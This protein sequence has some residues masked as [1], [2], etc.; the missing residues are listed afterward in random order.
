MTDFW[1]SVVWTLLITIATI[2]ADWIA[3][4]VI[5]LTRGIAAIRKAV[6]TGGNDVAAKVRKQLEHI[7]ARQV[8]TLT[9]G[10]DLAAVAIGLDLAVLGLWMSDRTLFPFF[11]RWDSQTAGGVVDRAIGVWLVLLLVHFVLL[12]ASIVLKHFHGDRIERVES[13]ALADLFQSGW[14]G[15]NRWMLVGNTLGFLVLLSSF[16]VVTNA[17]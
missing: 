7:R 5:L 2:L 9:W 11:Q 13:T 15:Q 10:A 3:G 4:R 17:I 14:L 1:L 16:L 6:E 8:A 12:L